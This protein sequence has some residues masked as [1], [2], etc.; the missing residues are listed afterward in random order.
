MSALPPPIL[1]VSREANFMPDLWP[2][3]SQDPAKTGHHDSS[4]RLF[5]T[6]PVVASSSLEEVRRWFLW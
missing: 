6:A 1:S 2:H 5:A 4:S 3:V